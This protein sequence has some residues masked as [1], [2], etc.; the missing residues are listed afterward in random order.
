MITNT[1]WTNTPTTPSLFDQ[2]YSIQVSDDDLIEVAEMLES[3]CP[4]L[5][6]WFIDLDVEFQKDLIATGRLFWEKRRGPCKCDCKCSD[7][8]PLQAVDLS[9][10]SDNSESPDPLPVPSVIQNPPQSGR[11]P[12]G[13][14]P[15][16]P[17]RPFSLLHLYRTRLGMSQAAVAKV[18][19][20]S[21]PAILRWERGKQNPKLALPHIRE[22]LERLFETPLEE[23]VRP[24]E[25]GTRHDNVC[26]G[27]N[28]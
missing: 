12:T 4:G 18:I 14:R 9:D 24:I 23:L 10:C 13:P 28:T 19:G 11:R 15:S 7:A 27:P 22:G 6:D 3:V 20:T 26:N 25:Q 8:L 21:Q 5:G 2:F 17:D 1:T 16:I